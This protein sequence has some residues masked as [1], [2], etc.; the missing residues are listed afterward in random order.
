M[1][2]AAGRGDIK[3][4]GTGG[5]KNGLAAIKS[6]LMHGTMDQSPTTDAKQALDIAIALA[7]GQSPKEKRNIIPM[8]KITSANVAS[9]A[10]EW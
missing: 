6:G 1:F 9:F 8:P 5:T 2:K 10:G 3:V 7:K 4:V